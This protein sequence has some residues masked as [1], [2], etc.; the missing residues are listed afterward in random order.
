MKNGQFQ[1]SYIK[2]SY[3]WFAFSLILIFIGLFAAGYKWWQTGR[4]FNL[5]IDFTGGTMLTIRSGRL[6]EINNLKLGEKN[7]ARTEF[8]KE[9]RQVFSG[10]GF[11]KSE[12]QI[13]EKDLLVRMEPISIDQRTKIMAELEQKFPGVELV[14]SDTIGPTIGKE[15][16]TQALG[17]ILLVLVAMTVY[18]SFRFELWYGIAAILALVHDALVTLGMAAVLNIEINIPFV[19]A[20][21]TILGYSINDTI[22]IF[23]RIRENVKFLRREK[24]STICDLSINQTLTRSI[25]TVLTTLLVVWALLFFG[26]ATIKDFTLALFIGISSGCYSSIFNASPLLVIF[27]KWQK[28]E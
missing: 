14:E 10:F 3:V 21:L 4:P 1:F 12:M 27:K 7:K 18:I 5:G 9:A 19:A 11:S 2:Y 16:R 22:V 17:M 15:L 6:G 24:F 26:G 8:L 13:S 25:N 28:A 20:I 23:D